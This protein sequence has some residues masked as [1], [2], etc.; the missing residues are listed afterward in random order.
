M[1]PWFFS[2]IAAVFMGV[3]AQAQQTNAPGPLARQL[4]DAFA[5]VYE[6]VA[7]GVVVIETTRESTALSGLPQGMNY[8]F[9]GPQGGG[10]AP[11]PSEGSGFILSPDGYIVTNY[12]VVEDAAEGGIN[13]QLKDD[14]KFKARLIGFDEETDIAV[15]KIDAENLPAL[16]L[17]DSD[18]VKV[19]QFAFAIGA[20]FALPYTFTVGVVSAKGRSRLIGKH[21]EGFENYIQ[22]DA[23]IN[24]GNSGGP[25]CDIDGRV[26]GMNTLISGLNRGLGFAVPS[27]MT[28]EISKQLIAS[29]RVM[30]PWLGIF[31]IGLEENEE[32]RHFFPGV[33]KGVLV[34]KIPQDTPAFASEL[35]A[36]DIIQKVDGVSVSM[37]KDLQREILSKQIGQSVDLTLV[38]NGREMKVSVR[39]GELPNRSVMKAALNTP[40][41]PGKAVRPNPSVKTNDF[42]VQVEDLPKGVAGV[43]VS[44]VVP[45]SPAS[46]AGLRRRDVITELGGKPVRSSAEFYA[47]LSTVDTERGAMVL[48]DREGQ[49]TFAILK[50]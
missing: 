40:M 11:E 14:R 35:Q 1:K 19:G 15:L 9:R 32:I 17:A 27:N 18:A 42:G 46:V 6:R 50:P 25:L 37:A 22:T 38:R 23:S 45:G 49:R 10:I 30:R 44:D 16:E 28:R 8:F 36:G 33:D 47:A 41:A 5:G 13:V 31:I 26:V 4:N 12:H 24:P 39:T 20:P 3:S 2:L 21:Y 48:L 29:G 43:T 7:P 34:Q